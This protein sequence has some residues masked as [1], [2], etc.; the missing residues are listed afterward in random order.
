VID[1]LITCWLGVLW[2]V[3]VSVKPTDRRIETTNG[4]WSFSGSVE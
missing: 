2:G 1:G 4:S 3:A